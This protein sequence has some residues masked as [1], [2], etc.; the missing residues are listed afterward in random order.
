M[1]SKRKQNRTDIDILIR[2][3]LTGKRVTRNR[4]MMTKFGKSK[5]FERSTPC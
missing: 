2:I 5:L 4:K 3:L 1:K